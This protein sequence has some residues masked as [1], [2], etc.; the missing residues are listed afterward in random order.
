[1]WK[2]LIALLLFLLTLAVSAPVAAKLEPAPSPYVVGI[3]RK[4]PSW[5]ADLNTPEGRSM[6]QGHI[7]VIR[8]MEATGKLIAAGPFGDPTDLR[9][10]LLFRNCSIDEARRMAAE[11]P[12][13]QSG[14]IAME[15]YTWMAPQKLKVEE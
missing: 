8:K 11:D 9:G 6:I 15:Y 13:V 4:G 2:P 5:R 12:V 3:R 14:Q 7:A 1:M 10:L